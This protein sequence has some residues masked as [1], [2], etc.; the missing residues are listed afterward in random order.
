MNLR[1]HQKLVG[2]GLLDQPR[3]GRAHTLGIT[4]DGCASVGRKHRFFLFIERV[5]THL[6]RARQRQ[7]TLAL[8]HPHDDTERA[9]EAPL[10]ADFSTLLAGLRNG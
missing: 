2:G 9:W 1:H 5:L 4:D 3:Q 10:P 8:R 6:G 7:V